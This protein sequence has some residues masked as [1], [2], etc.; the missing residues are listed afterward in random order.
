MLDCG[1][2][3]NWNSEVVERIA[4]V[5]KMPRY[6]AWC[7]SDQNRM[8]VREGSQFNCMSRIVKSI[9]IS[10]LS[11]AF[12]TP[13]GWDLSLWCAST[14]ASD[15]KCTSIQNAMPKE[16]TALVHFALEQSEYMQY[17]Y[18]YVPSTSKCRESHIKLQTQSHLT[19]RS[20]LPPRILRSLMGSQP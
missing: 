20:F 4:F 18:A 15:R 10:G 16:A 3:Y 17:I 13:R 9:P 6:V 7:D 19:S 2:C 12:S 8:F 14:N 11:E 1:A 5:S